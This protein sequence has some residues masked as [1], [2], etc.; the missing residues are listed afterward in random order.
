MAEPKKSD[1]LKSPVVS[2]DIKQHDV[3]PLV[4]AMAD[5]AFQARNLGRAARIYDAML[6]DK[7]CSVI[8][9]LAGSLCSAGLR[10]VF[11]DLIEHRMADAI[12]STGA[13]IVDQDFFEA[14]GFR[15]WRGEIRVD[16]DQ[17]RRLAIDRI[18]DTYIDEDELRIC[19]ETVA[20][21]ADEMLVAGGPRAVS[22]REFLRE[23]GAWLERERPG[24]RSI[25][26]AAYRADV[27]IFVPAF[28]DC[29]AGFGLVHHQVQHPDGYIA[30]DSAADFRELT[31]LKLAAGATG[32]LMIGG[33]VPKNFAQ[34]V[35]VAAEVLGHDVE[36]HRYAV[37]ITVADERDGALSGSTLREAN[38]W[39]KV[40]L[41][42]EQMVYA[43][44]TVALPLV[45]GYAFHKGAWRARKATRYARLFAAAAAKSGD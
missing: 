23:M 33:G 11:I 41:G 28:S 5:M 27:P 25:V 44:A 21:I 42:E 24:G 34:D 1:I 38:S 4:D 31:Q 18:Y 36:M 14:L 15:H 12:V 30:L 6:A 17:L 22:S 29:S 2:I 35:V 9:C 32:L 3:R 43:E 7:E 40:K 19:D 10:D 13:N 45:A 37:Q 39:G 16:D 26:A 20:G 8:V